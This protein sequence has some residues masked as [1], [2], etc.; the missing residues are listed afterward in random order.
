MGRNDCVK[1]SAITM[2][3]ITLRASS[4]SR[5]GAGPEPADFFLPIAL[6]QG[7]DANAG[8]LK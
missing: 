1:E 6:G 2:A 4:C 5:A 7:V 8:S 3:C